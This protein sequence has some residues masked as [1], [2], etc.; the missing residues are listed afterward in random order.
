MSDQ[1][2][3]HDQLHRIG[4]CKCEE[5]EA[6]LRA[7]EVRSGLQFEQQICQPPKAARYVQA[8]PAAAPTGARETAVQF[9]ARQ[10]GVWGMLMGFTPNERKPIFEFAEAY[11][12]S[13]LESLRPLLL[14]LRARLTHSDKCNSRNANHVCDCGK[15]KLEKEI[16]Q[17]VKGETGGN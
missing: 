4:V 15:E 10:S 3:S 16:D 11:A 14:R 9:W 12:A 1:R 2:V 13:Q 6:N 8:Q 7:A 5:G 17:V